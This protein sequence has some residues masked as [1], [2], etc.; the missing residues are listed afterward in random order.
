MKKI[1]FFIV[2]ALLAIFSL[3]GCYSYH[4]GAA[5]SQ[6][7]IDKNEAHGKSSTV[8]I[9]QLLGGK[10]GSIQKAAQDGK[11]DSIYRV[12][13]EKSV[14][15]GGLIGILTTHVYGHPSN[16]DDKGKTSNAIKKTNNTTNKDDIYNS[17]DKD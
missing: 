11:I 17:Q 5:I 7:N 9:L 15:F 8:V 2:C 12:E 1:T 6:P 4:Y 13:Y 16:V 10:G 3:S 14:I